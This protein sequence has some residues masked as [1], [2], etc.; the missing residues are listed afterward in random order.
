MLQNIITVD[1]STSVI[2]T[3][4]TMLSHHIGG[5]PATDRDGAPIGILSDDD[6]VRRV[7]VGT[8]K[9]R[10]RWLALLAGANQWGNWQLRELV[11]QLRSAWIQ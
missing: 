9:H 3:I 10:G 6:F 2:D 7:E 4:S 1:A 5:L 8:E 11:A